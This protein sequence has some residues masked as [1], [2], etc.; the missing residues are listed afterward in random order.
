LII[1]RSDLLRM[2]TVSDGPCRE[3]QNTQ[4]VFNNFLF[5]KSCRLLDNVE[6]YCRGG[7]ATDG[8]MAHAHCMLDTWGCKYTLRICNIYCISTTTVVARTRLC[9]TL[10][11]SY[12]PCRVTFQA[13]SYS[14]WNKLA[15]T[16]HTWRLLQRYLIRNSA[17]TPT[18]LT[19]LSPRPP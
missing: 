15:Q 17:G 14:Y 13:I 3:N 4:F 16:W 8:N 9:V 18:T 10:R 1:A 2:R 19:E 12:F 6:K 7:R 5:R 11:Y